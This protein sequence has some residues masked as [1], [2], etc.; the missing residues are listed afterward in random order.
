MLVPDRGDEG[1]AEAPSFGSSNMLLPLPDET[2][3]SG[4]SIRRHPSYTL[5]LAMFSIPCRAPVKSET[6]TPSSSCIL[7]ANSLTQSRTWKNLT[8]HVMIQDYAYF[9][10]TRL[11]VQDC[12]YKIMHRKTYALGA[13]GKSVKKHKDVAY[14]RDR[15]ILGGKGNCVVTQGLAV[16]RRTICSFLLLYLVNIQSPTVWP[17]TKG[18]CIVNLIEPHHRRASAS[19]SVSAQH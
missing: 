5:C 3:E 9:M 19:M 11:C 12:A 7:V 10:R 15:R 4:G 2:S 14:G 16:S 13:N 8:W 6:S 17:K 1:C 18:T